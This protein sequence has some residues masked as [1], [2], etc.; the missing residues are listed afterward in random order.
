[1][2]PWQFGVAIKADAAERKQKHELRAWHTWHIAALPRFKTFPSLSELTK[3]ESNKKGI[4]EAA[5][6]ARLRAYQN[7]KDGNAQ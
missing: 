6:K 7:K 1:M 4:D 3:I 5:L 2:T